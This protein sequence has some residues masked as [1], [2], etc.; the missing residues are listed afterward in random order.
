MKN[1]KKIIIFLLL[2]PLILVS[3]GEAKTK[4]ENETD[5]PTDTVIEE[6]AEYVEQFTVHSEEGIEIVVSGHYFA[7][8]GETGLTDQSTHVEVLWHNNKD[9]EYDLCT[10][11]N[12]VRETE[13]GWEDASGEWVYNDVLYVLR[14]GGETMMRY[15]LNGIKLTDGVKYRLY[16]GSFEE[17]ENYLEFTPPVI[18]SAAMAYDRFFFTGDMDGVDY[19][20]VSLNTKTQQYDIMLKL[21]MDYDPSGY[22]LNA[23]NGEIVLYFGNGE[24]FGKMK[25]DGE[26]LVW[27]E[28]GEKYKFFEEGTVFE[29]YEVIYGNVNTYEKLPDGTYRMDDMKYKYRLEITGRLNGAVKD[30]TFVYL[31]NL[32]NITFGQAWKAAGLSSNMKDYFK[33]EDAVLVE[34]E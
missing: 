19:S 9:A 14:P 28:S 12:L 33:P 25:K 10:Y 29:P 30:S 8:D 3:C 32:E 4:T 16:M 13:N 18:Y 21:A 17:T 7:N 31:S 24:V 2:L 22:Y 6:P 26:N 27:T 5:L 15:D 20:T 34:I 23:E 11:A 1:M